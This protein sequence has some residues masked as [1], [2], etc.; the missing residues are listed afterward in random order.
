MKYNFKESLFALFKIFKK[1][2]FIFVLFSC[3][4]FTFDF[5]AVRFYAHLIDNLSENKEKISLE[6]KDICFYFLVL[7]LS[8]ILTFVYKKFNC[9]FWK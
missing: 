9:V 4:I 5:L 2:I 6:N 8:V 3:F 1:Y 7:F